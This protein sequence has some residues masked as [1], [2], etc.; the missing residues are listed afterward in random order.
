MHQRGGLPRRNASPAHRLS[1]GQKVNLIRT[2]WN[3][4]NRL[5]KR[6]RSRI[7]FSTYCRRT[8]TPGKLI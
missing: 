1:L 2:D 6:I 3:A 5:R 7:I 4:F 8:R